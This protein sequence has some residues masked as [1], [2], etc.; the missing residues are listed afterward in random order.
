MTGQKT[1]VKKTMKT[2]KP[3]FGPALASCL[4]YAAFGSAG[5]IPFPVLAVEAAGAEDEKINFDEITPEQERVIEKGLESLA[6]NQNDK[7]GSWGVSGQEAAHKVATTAIAGLAF[8][9]HG[10]TPT[11]GKYA[12]NIRKA[13]D[14]ILKQSDQS[15]LIKYQGQGGHSPMHEHGYAMLFL[16]QVYGMYPST[17]TNKEIGNALRKA[18]SL[19]SRSQSSLGGWYYTPDSASHEGSV[20]VTQIEGLRSARNAGIDVPKKTIQN[21]INFMKVSQNTNG[22]IMYMPGQSGQGSIAL[23]AAGVAVMFNTGEFNKETNEIINKSL[24]HLENALKKAGAVGM[25]QGHYSY[26]HLYMAQVMFLAGPKYWNIYFPQI[27]K[28]LIET[29]GTNGSW[30]GDIGSEIASAIALIVLQIPYRFL[31]I[32]QK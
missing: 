13:V 28:H 6:R 4:A 23:T 1:A 12:P 8:L 24:R 26:T 29:Q 2:R 21:A 31:P 32:L 25:C 5:A 11:R 9:A 16:G 15:G 10:D 20:T 19:T 14:F 18:V 3:T 7:E 17:K 27:R 30:Q 22:S